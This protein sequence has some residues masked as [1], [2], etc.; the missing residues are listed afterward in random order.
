MSIWYMSMDP[1]FGVYAAP[2]APGTVGNSMG[3]MAGR[4]PLGESIRSLLSSVTTKVSLA[5]L[6]SRAIRELESLDDRL[7][8]DIGLN[9]FNIAREVGAAIANVGNDVAA[10]PG[11]IVDFPTA[12]EHEADH[13]QAA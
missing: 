1:R 3:S 6:R 10:R 11:V 13:K 2:K 9:R 4:L 5:L 7:L 12:P 8:A